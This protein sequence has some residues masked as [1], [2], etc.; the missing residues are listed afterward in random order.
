MLS[1]DPSRASSSASSDNPVCY[2]FATVTEGFSK[3]ML[4]VCSGETRKKVIY[5]STSNELTIG[6]VDRKSAPQQSM[7]FLLEYKGKKG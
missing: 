7:Q 5:I 4:T 1:S 2:Q 6:F 3:R